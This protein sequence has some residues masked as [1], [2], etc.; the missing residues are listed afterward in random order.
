[1]RAAAA[2]A[3][4]LELVEAGQLH[5]ELQRRPALAARE[6][7]EQAGVQPLGPRGFHL[8]PDEAHGAVA[9]HG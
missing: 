4:G 3:Q 1:A 6:R 2:V 9:V 7:Y 5:L 8:A